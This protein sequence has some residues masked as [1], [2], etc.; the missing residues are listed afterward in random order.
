MRKDCCSIV[1]EREISMCGVLPVAA[2]LTAAALI[3]VRE[4]IVLHYHTSGDITGERQ[5]VVGYGAA[6][7]FRK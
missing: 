1:R 4:G 7:L 6:A 2:T 3:G 5:E